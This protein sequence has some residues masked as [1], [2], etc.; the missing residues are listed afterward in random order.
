MW[1]SRELCTPRDETQKKEKPR[2]KL[3]SQ[4]Y[5]CKS[6]ATDVNGMRA[7][8][9]PYVWGKLALH[10]NKRG[11]GLL[12]GNDIYRSKHTHLAELK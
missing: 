9:V 6:K 3:C 12:L 5:G 4:V 10:G 7:E 8:H 2:V 1:E 11:H